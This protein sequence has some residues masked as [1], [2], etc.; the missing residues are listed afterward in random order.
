M[1]TSSQSVPYPFPKNLPLFDLAET[2]IIAL[3]QVP[4]SE[5]P[6]PKEKNN[7]KIA[8]MCNCMHTC[9]WIGNLFIFLLLTKLL[10]SKACKPVVLVK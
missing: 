9:L 3:Q 5:Y 10:K 6:F 1:Y 8:K 2:Y 7:H 4:L